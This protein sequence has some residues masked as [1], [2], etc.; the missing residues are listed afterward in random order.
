MIALVADGDGVPGGKRQHAAGDVLDSA[1]SFLAP[2][3]AFFFDLLSLWAVILLISAFI[4]RRRIVVGQTLALAGARG[5]ARV[6]CFSDIDGAAG[7]RSARCSAASSVSMNLPAVRVVQAAV[8]VLAISPHLT[9]PLQSL[10]RWLLTLGVLAAFFADNATPGGNLEAL[11]IA[12]I[13]ATAVR[14]AF[15]TSAGYPELDE[16]EAA[17]AQLGVPATDLERVDR[18]DTGAFVARGRDPD[19]LPLIV[20]VYGRDAYD[21]QLVEKLWRTAW[22][23]D[24]GPGLRVS[25]SQAVEHEAFVTLLAENA[26]RAHPPGGDCGHVGLRR[27]AAGAARQRPAVGRA[28]R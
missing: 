8:V 6:R 21:N 25:R 28:A 17:L 24:P 27:R 19:G 20:K 14:L 22:Y 12:V 23:R 7:P 5:G 1:P 9:R 11:L 3:W 18:G 10:T 16:V 13:A 26:G 4:R 15:G 2:V